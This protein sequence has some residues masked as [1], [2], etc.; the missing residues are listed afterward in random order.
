MTSFTSRLRSRLSRLTGRSIYGSLLLVVFGGLV[1]PALIGSYVLIG[2][3]QRQAA[4]SQLDESLQRNADILALGM[5]ESLWNMNPESARS[6]AA[7]VMR[8]PS[9]VGVEVLDQSGRQFIAAFAPPRAQ[10]NVVRAQREVTVRGERIGRVVLAMDDARTQEELH[11]KQVSYALVLASQLGVS[12]VLIVLFLNRRLLSPLRK[13]MSFSDR[14]SHGDFTTRLDMGGN[15]ELGRL[16]IQLDQMRVAIRHLFDDVARREERFRTIVTQV[17]GAVFRVNADGK[18]DFVSDA[19]EAIGGFPASRLIGNSVGLWQ[20]MVA[21]EDRREQYRVM[22]GAVAEGRPYEA[23]YRI[24]SPSGSERWVA[25]RGQP[26]YDS[27][28]KLLWVDGLISD[29]S[30]RKYNEMRIEALLA[31]QS[32]ILE[33]V[34][35][36]VMFVRHRRIVSV[37]R[38][39]EELFGYAPGEMLHE[40]TVIV[41]P[42]E[43]EYELAGVRQYPEIGRG[44][45]FSEERKYKR[46]DGSLFW[47]MVSGCALDPSR[48]DE[49]SIWV[50]ADITERKL[51]EEKLRLSA[52]VLEQIADGVMVVDVDGRIVAVN[53]AF[54]QITGYTEEEALGQPYNLTRSS[55]HDQSFYDELWREVQESGYWRG[56]LWNLRRNGELYLEWLT[57]SAVRDN[58]GARTHYVGVFSDI[59]KVRESQEQL[60]HM[61]H[62]DPLTQLPNRLLFHDR[63]QHALQR[64]SRDQEQLALL[65]ID[66]DR[67]KNVNDTLGH[68]TGDELLKQVARALTGKLREGDT[69]ARLGG[70]EFIVLLEDVA[71]AGGAAHVAEKLVAL[72]EQPFMVSGYE[73][74]V[75]ASVGIA[76]Y[77]NDAGDLNMLIRNADVAMYQAKARGRNGYQF[78]TESMSGEGVERLRLETLLRR[79]IEKGEIFLHYQPQ[80]EI[81]SGRLIGV[82][83]L[84][85]WQN[86]ELGLV[87][88]ARFVPLAEDTGFINQLGEWVLAEACRQMVRW[89]EAGFAVPK[90]AVNLSARQ[91]ERGSIVSTVGEV[92]KETGLAPSRLQL[93]VTETVI[94]NTG[95]ALAFINGL[96][97]IGVGLAIDDF[98]TGYS[99]LAYLKQLPVQTLKIDRSFI[100][101]IS[102][103]ANDEAIA[104][105]II[106][107][108]KSL[109]LSVV[110]EGVE[111]D[112]QA[113]FLLRHGC[114]MAQGYFYSR[115]VLPGDLLGA[116]RR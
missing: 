3:Q 65:F 99:S 64:A 59:T 37:N 101:D 4:R 116:W 68:H 39:C 20:D 15:D 54:T 102:T 60:D 108:G 112:D 9:V 32:A 87:P 22:A 111:T 31:E 2:V 10:G 13:L 52:T 66:L 14:L 1:I 93:E 24:I 61:A 79:S 106:Q 45:Y 84:V 110:A 46:A 50:Y 17:P 43:A 63:L 96:H 82:E 38:R 113:A 88:P 75:T 56:E 34:M 48:P 74:F 89:D 25:E 5:Q 35:F 62:H 72:F 6:L 71:G 26:Q 18:V 57:I 55:R 67:F 97:E 105:A 92:L 107:L 28:G 58:S 33:N 40:S 76:M 115:P 51:A 8:D 27:E 16:A 44:G 47:T 78:Y 41:F 95:D 98:G 77:P 90:V 109:N 19:I 53:P 29:I 30:E 114:T 104:I 80:V 23:E 83:A 36:G 42:T 12:L 69:L 94:M 11:E 81:D 103:D 7:S 91:F 49:G 21:P 86:P 100:K 73:L 85:R 70:D